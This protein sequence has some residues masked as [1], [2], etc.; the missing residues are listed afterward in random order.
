MKQRS[1]KK[2]ALLNM[3][4]SIGNVLCS[5]LSLP[6]VTRVLQ[7]ENYGKVSY[8]QS[9][10]SYFAL[11]AELGILSYAMRECANVRDDQEKYTKLANEMFTFNVAATVIS[12]ILAQLVLWT[13]PGF[14]SHWILIEIFLVSVIFDTLRV[15]WL[16]QSQEDY[17]YLSLQG[18][19]SHALVLI[20]VYLIVKR[21]EDFYKYAVILIMPSVIPGV[22]NIL[23]SRKYCM[24]RLT[25]H[26]NIKNHFLPIILIFASNVANMIYVF[27][28]TLILGY[29]TGDYAVGLYA[30][31][32]RIYDTTKTLLSA[33]ISVTIP[34]FCYYYNNQQEK[35][36]GD[37]LEKVINLVLLIAIPALIGLSVLSEEIVML[38]FGSAYVE[39]TFALRLLSIAL[40]FAVPAMLLSQSVLIAMKKERTVFKVTAL[41]AATNVV[42]NFILIPQ[43]AQNAAAFTTL[44]CEFMVFTIYLVKTKKLWHGKIR[45]K[46]LVQSIFAGL[47]MGVLV[48]MIK[49]V[50]SS[51]LLS[52]LICLFAGIF[53]YFGILLLLHNVVVLEYWN[54]GMSWLKRNG[55]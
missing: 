26:A 45:L 29:L 4:T 8:A 10:V 9:F 21:P 15:R 17:S 20:L 54:Q 36:F 48:Y 53:S 18:L 38:L 16:Y 55:S 31:V 47:F 52:V 41:G 40:L 19:F 1:I 32:V 42:L 12:M 13:V 34:R 7:P 33:G 44:F 5:V 39:S 2:N 51:L 14:K 6:Y 49:S 23:R 43:Y 35:E 24:L 37:L 11:L 46:S 50:F 27:S 3:G 30:V 25:F 28:D 22:M